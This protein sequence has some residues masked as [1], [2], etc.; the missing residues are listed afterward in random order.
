[1][2][3]NIRLVIRLFTNYYKDKNLQR[4]TELEFCLDQNLNNSLI[5]E[6]I[7]LTDESEAP[8]HKKIKVVKIGGRPTYTD[9]FRI[10]NERIG[11]E[12]ISIISNSDIYFNDTLKEVTKIVK[13]EC[14]SLTRWDLN[15]SARL[16]FFNRNDSQDAWIFRGPIPYIE[17]N[18]NL[19]KPGCDNRIAFEI[20]KTGF[21]VRNPSFSIQA[22]HVHNSAVRNFDWNDTND[23]ISGPY[24]L[25]DPCNA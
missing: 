10:A 16:S 1:M 2:Q 23:R 5:S 24:H 19:G 15:Q 22:I 21:K 7:L 13:R 18:F 3:A 4:Q 6:V 8:K 20:N 9:F 25:V 17:G 14:F 12:D 11:A